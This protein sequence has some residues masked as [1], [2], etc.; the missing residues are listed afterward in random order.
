MLDNRFYR[1]RIHAHGEIA[2]VMYFPTK[3][4][5]EEYINDPLPGESF[6][7]GI[8]ELETSDDPKVLA[9][10]LNFQWALDSRRMLGPGKR[11]GE[12]PVASSGD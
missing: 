8:N 3:K 6:P 9:V 11:W 1:V 4:E 5:A 12:E 10:Q 2:R 7:C